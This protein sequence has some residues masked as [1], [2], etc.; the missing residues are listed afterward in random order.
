MYPELEA[1]I[2]ACYKNIFDMLLAVFTGKDVR[3]E[4]LAAST[5]AYVAVRVHACD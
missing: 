1:A 2:D 3:I 5:G 4:G